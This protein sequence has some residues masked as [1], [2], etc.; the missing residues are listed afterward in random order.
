MPASRALLL[1]GYQN[2]TSFSKFARRS[3]RTDGDRG[4]RE[5]TIMAAGFRRITAETDNRLNM[6]VIGQSGIGKTC[7]RELPGER[8]GARL[9]RRGEAYERP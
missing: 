5:E 6:S 1:S 7:S 2:G 3:G 8:Q 9:E 4:Y